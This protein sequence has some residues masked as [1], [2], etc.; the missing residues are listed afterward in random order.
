MLRNLETDHFQGIDHLKLGAEVLKR[1]NFSDIF[2][3]LVLNHHEI[4]SNGSE[5]YQMLNKIMVYSNAIFYYCNHDKFEKNTPW[6]I[7][8]I[9]KFEVIEGLK[10][11]SG[12]NLNEDVFKVINTFTL[13]NL[14]Q[15]ETE[16][17]ASLDDE[18]TKI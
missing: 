17:T 14:S 16:K 3:E 13:E 7:E 1:W 18:D 8:I 10:R 2:V 11:L 12:C 5:I 4:C 6:Y 9:D 15:R